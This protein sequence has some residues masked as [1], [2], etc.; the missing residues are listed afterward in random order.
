[1]ANSNQET[2]TPVS[3]QQRLFVPEDEEVLKSDYLWHYRVQ[4]PA[5][6]MWLSYCDGVLV[7]QLQ[8]G[9]HTW[10]SGP[11]PK[12]EWRILKINTHIE[13]LDG[14]PI[15]GRVKPPPLPSHV[16]G[17]SDVEMGCDVTAEM[18]IECKIVNVKRFLDY[19][20][21]L[22]IFLAS[23]QDMVV[24]LIGSLPY[25]QYGQWARTIR[26]EVRG[27]LIGGIDDAETRLGIQVS[28]VLVTDFKANGTSDRAMLA[29]FQTVERGRRDLVEAVARSQ[30]DQ[31]K[32]DSA[33]AQGSVLNIPP[34]ILA[35]QNSPIGAALI[36]RD[37][38]LRKLMV[39]AGLAPAVNIQPAQD[40]LP[41]PGGQSSASVYLNP[42]QLAPGGSTPYQVS[43]SLAQSG[44]FTNPR[45][46]AS[47]F[48]SAMGSTPAPTGPSARPPSSSY[49]TP[50]TPLSTDMAV[51]PQPGTSEAPPVDSTRQRAEMEALT[52]AGFTV[53]EGKVSPMYDA[54]GMPIPNTSEWVISIYVQAD[55]G[56]LTIIFHCPSG[57]PAQA[58]GVQIKRPRGNLTW[59]NEPNTILNWHPGRLLVEVAQE[60]CETIP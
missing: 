37:A 41:Q 19:R 56:Y 26:D 58:P 51:P 36:E 10:W 7:E 32:A 18:A 23:L 47:G 13:L 25:D 9:R 44:Y 30:S 53:V 16:V 1:M 4:V 33:A 24:D 6:E 50:T 11:I 35:L 57:Y 3:P 29:M 55:T 39:A 22:S 34:A 15:K 60:L 28:K 54:T 27:R 8:P 40:F 5:G 12:H 17:A 20:D 21:P 42:P 43:G 38:E 48:P 45:S 52:G 2:I 14:I 59:I 46:Q 31:V 49:F